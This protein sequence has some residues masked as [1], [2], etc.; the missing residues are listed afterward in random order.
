MVTSQGHKTSVSPPLSRFDLFAPSISVS[1]RIP[2]DD[3]EPLGSHR[4][5]EYVLNHFYAQATLMLKRFIHVCDIRDI[6]LN[7]LSIF[8]NQHASR[9]I[10]FFNR[11]TVLSTSFPRSKQAFYRLSHQFN[12]KTGTIPTIKFYATLL[13]SELRAD[14]NAALD[15]IHRMK[16]PVVHKKSHGI[17]RLSR[18]DQIRNLCRGC[19]RAL[20]RVIAPCFVNVFDLDTLISILKDNKPDLTFFNTFPQYQALFLNTSAAYAALEYSITNAGRSLRPNYDTIV[21]RAEYMK[22]MLLFENKR[23]LRKLGEDRS[24]R[25]YT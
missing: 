10:A 17:Q 16:T 9:L 25:R 19:L 11:D 23:A 13:Q 3:L 24:P 2:I 20:D 12:I 4:T 15:S 8:F 18:A 7:R 22:E 1:H 5:P 21:R 14:Y 6:D